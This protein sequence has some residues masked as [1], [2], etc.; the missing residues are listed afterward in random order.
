MGRGLRTTSLRKATAWDRRRGGTG[1]GQVDA[2]AGQTGVDRGEM[3]VD[4]GQQLA[5]GMLDVDRRPQELS[6]DSLVFP[7]HLFKVK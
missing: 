6:Q 5:G 2:A 1:G 4:C 7:D 3:S